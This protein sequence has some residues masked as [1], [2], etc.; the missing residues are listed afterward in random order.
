MRVRV[1]RDRQLEALGFFAG[2]RAA[3]V[4]DDAGVADRL[5]VG[6]IDRAL[7]ELEDAAR[8]VVDQLQPAL[9]VDHQHAFDHA[10]EDRFHPRAIARQAV[11]APA[12]LLHRL[13]HRPR[14]A[15]EVVVAVVG[16]RAAQVA[17]A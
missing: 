8:G 10:R 2:Q 15:A 17:E 4:F 9:F 13:V 1:A 7:F 14:H 12:E 5:D 16:R 6:V 3:D 11:D